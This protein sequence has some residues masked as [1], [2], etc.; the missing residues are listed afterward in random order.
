LM[1]S[2][3]TLISTLNIIHPIVARIIDIQNIVEN[4]EIEAYEDII[5]FIFTPV[6]MLYEVTC[7]C[8]FVYMMSTR[9]SQ[10]VPGTI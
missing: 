6:A 7:F 9:V 5:E 3:E 1:A 10:G 4:K 8:Y 2:I